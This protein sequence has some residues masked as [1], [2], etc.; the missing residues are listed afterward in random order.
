MKALSKKFAAS[1]TVYGLNRVIKAKNRLL[2]VVWSLMA[3]VSVSFG[4]FVILNTISTFL[5][6]EVFTQTKRIPATSSLMPSVSFCLYASE[7]KDLNAFFANAQFRTLGYL[8]SN[9]T[10]E[11]FYEKY[12]E[13]WGLTDCIKF[14]HY[15]NK[16]DNRLFTAKSLDDFLYFKIDLKKRFSKMYVLLSDNYEN[17]LDWSKLVTISYNV[18]GK[19]SISF[20]KEVELKLG[21]P[22]NLCQNVSD[23]TY[24]R[25]NCLAQC[26]NRNFVRK[27]NCTFGNYYFIPGYE[28]CHDIFSNSSEFDSVCEE[29]CPKEC[30][31]IKFNIRH[32]NPDMGSNS[33]DSLEFEVWYSDLSYIEISQTPKMTGFS[34]MNEIGGALGLFVGITFLSLLELF[35]FFFEIFLVFYR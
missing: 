4:F 32:D 35:E 19:Y 26:W 16:N 6:Y 23:I 21:E 17:T 28:F 31:T 5:K 7:N 25:S 33:S 2:K 14:N 30:T 20:R 18:K 9:L 22:Y 8:S 29:Q 27:Y 13:D 15:A 10:G 1:T 24:R 3:L 34:L 11:Q 12:F